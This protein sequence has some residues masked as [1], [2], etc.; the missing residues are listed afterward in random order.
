VVEQV[1]GVN[2]ADQAAVPRTRT[3]DIRSMAAAARK[4]RRLGAPAPSGEGK[5]GD[6]EER[7]AAVGETGEKPGG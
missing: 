5:G 1:E 6:Q 4:I 7:P 2:H 3:G